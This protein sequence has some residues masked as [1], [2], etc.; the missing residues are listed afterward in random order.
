MSEKNVIKVIQV[1]KKAYHNYTVIEDLETGISLAG[2][3]VKSIREGKISFSD[4]YC[5]IKDG[6][7]ML[8]GMT[9]QPYEKGSIF[10][11]QPDRTRTLLAHKQEIKKLR[12]KVEEKGMTLVPTKIYIKGNFVK[13]QVSLCRGKD[14]HDKKEALKQRD[15]HRQAMRDIAVS[16]I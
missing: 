6:Q 5:R 9:I 4:S 12:R 11:H 10:N 15:L 13:I 7:L 2:T 8:V 16:G 14:V 1:N 3:E